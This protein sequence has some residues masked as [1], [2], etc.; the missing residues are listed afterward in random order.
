[1]LPCYKY[2]SKYKVST[3]V[4]YHYKF[5]SFIDSKLISV[6]T[7]LYTYSHPRIYAEET[8]VLE[9]ARLLESDKLQSPF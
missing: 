3:D 2:K 9:T 5:D 8:P 6:S 7:S 1:M 4:I